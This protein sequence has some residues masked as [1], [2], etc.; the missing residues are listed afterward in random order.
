MK[1]K[2]LDSGLD[3]K[4]LKESLLQLGKLKLAEIAKWVFNELQTV[5]WSEVWVES[6]NERHLGVD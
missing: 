6:G 5:I 2:D 4:D 1:K 3:K